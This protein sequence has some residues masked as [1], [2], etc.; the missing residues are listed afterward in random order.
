MSP[1]TDHLGKKQPD[2]LSWDQQA[3]DAF[4][5][6]QHALVTMPVLLNPNFPQPFVVQ[7][8]VSSSGVK[9]VLPQV[10]KGEEHPIIL[11]T[12]VT[13][14]NQQSRSIRPLT[15]RALAAKWAVEMLQFYLVN[16]PFTLL[17]DHTPPAVAP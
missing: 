11:Y 17:M 14:A 7:M 13:N 6:L 3:Q 15:G 10:L 8:D 5:D 1:L 2:K 16:N 9:V 12:S 4:E